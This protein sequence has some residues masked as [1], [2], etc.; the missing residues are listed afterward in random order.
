MISERMDTFPVYPVL[1]YP[2]P[3]G[4]SSITRIEYTPFGQ[5]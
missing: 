3:I 5:T 2:L 1:D 4:C